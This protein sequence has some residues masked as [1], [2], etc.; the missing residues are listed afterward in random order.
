MTVYKVFA[1]VR[2]IETPEDEDFESRSES[3]ELGCF[4][5]ED[6]ALEFLYSL[7][8]NPDKMAPELEE[9][10]APTETDASPAP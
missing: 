8:S 10:E 1:Q 4:G 9:K 2:R 7:E 5:T 6:M 3:E